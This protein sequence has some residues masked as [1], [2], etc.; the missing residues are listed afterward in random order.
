MRIA[1]A[2]VQQAYLKPA[3]AGNTQLQDRFGSSVAVS[4]DTVVGGAIW[5]DSASLGVNSNPNESATNAGTAYVW[6]R[7]GPFISEVIDAGSLR[8]EIAAS[9]WVTIKGTD[10]AA[11]TRIWAGADFV[12]ERLP[13]A[14]DGIRVTIDGRPAAI[15]YI[16]PTQLNVLSGA[17]TRTG[18]VNVV[19]TTP[20][21]TDTFTATVR[22]RVPAWFML[23]PENRKYV[24]AANL[25]GTIVGKAGLYPSAPNA[26]K[27]LPARGGRVLIYGTGWGPTDPVAPDGT[28]FSAASPLAAAVSIRIGGVQVLIEFAGVV[29]PGL[30][31]FNI[32]A[33]DLPPG[34][35]R[36]RAPS[37]GSP[38]KPVHSSR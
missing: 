7:T 1:G 37:P 16:S 38:R 17:L 15:Y 31:Q 35:T 2:W 23:D 3:N 24:A 29:T 18:P 4:G 26:T 21:G 25:D 13:T 30:Y 20:T 10:L 32:V 34:I 36:L 11:T 9:S 33:P 28:V 5:E 14:L 6:F 27:P 12:Q 19:V 22:D 8:P